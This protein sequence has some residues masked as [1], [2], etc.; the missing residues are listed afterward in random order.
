MQIFL[1]TNIEQHVANLS[2]FVAHFGALVTYFGIF[3][4]TSESRVNYMG[5]F[6][7]VSLLFQV[8]L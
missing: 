2:I 4:G 6:N 8:T 5:D 1:A 3:K 7:Y